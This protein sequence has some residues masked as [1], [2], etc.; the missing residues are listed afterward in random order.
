MRSRSRFLFAHRARRIEL[1]SG[2]KVDELA[3]SELVDDPAL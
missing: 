2:I 1:L 3:V